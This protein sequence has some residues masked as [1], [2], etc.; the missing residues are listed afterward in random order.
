LDG[1]PAQK[2]GLKPGDAI[3]KVDDQA[4][5]GWS[6]SQVVEKIR[7]QKG[8]EVKLA[9][10]HKSGEQPV[11]VKITRD[12]ITVKS[13]TSWTKPIKNVD[14]INT[15]TSALS[16]AADQKIVYI[17]LSQFGDDTNTEWASLATKIDQQLK[18]DQS[19]KGVVFD[20]R[21]NPGGYLTDAVYIASEFIKD[22]V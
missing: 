15:K 16:Q 7:G 18:T 11:D 3:L 14:A 10:I 19:I 17:R 8:T 20:L 1:S 6:L 21:N 22:G 5:A 13:L 9:I 12:T 4:T 2:A